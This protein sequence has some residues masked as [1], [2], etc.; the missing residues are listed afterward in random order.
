[1]PHRLLTLGN[2]FVFEDRNEGGGQRAFAQQSAEE[3]GH[4]EGQ[5]EGARVERVLEVR[6]GQQ[7]G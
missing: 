7:L 6:A 4:L 2:L 5:G 1:M 3:I